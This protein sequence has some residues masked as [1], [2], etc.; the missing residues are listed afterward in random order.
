MT[1]LSAFLSDDLSTSLRGR[2]DAYAYGAWGLSLAVA[3]AQLAARGARG[4]EDEAARWLGWSAAA[5]GGYAILQSLGFDPIFKIKELPTGGRAV[6]TLGSPVD[7][8][9]FLALLWPVA[10]R[11]LDAERG[12][13]PAVLAAAVAGGLVASGSRGALLAACAGTAGYWLMSRREGRSALPAALGIAALASA[14]AVSWSF[15]SGAT[16]RDLSRIEVWK[17]ALAAFQRRP[18]LGWGPDGFEDAFKMLRSDRF[19]EL[20]GSST[21]QAY[22]HNDLLH[23]LS[24]MGLLGAA[25]Y[26]WLLV[27]LCLAAK[28]A[29]QAPEGRARAAALFSGL[30]ALWVNLAL[31]PVATEVVVLAAVCAGL[32]ASAT[33][34]PNSREAPRPLLV[35]LAGLASVSL[36]Y[37]AVLARADASYKRGAKAHVAGDFAAARKHIAFA[38]RTAPCELSYIT[39][40][41]NA[42]HD[43]INATRVVDARL[44]LLALADA[45]GAA[46]VAC[47]PRKSLAHYAAGSAARMRA[48]LGFSDRLPVAIGEFDR[49]LEL[50]PKFVPLLNARR[51]AARLLPPAR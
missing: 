39:G 50:D 26:A 13:L 11:R 16:V 3:A 18:W 15:R 20:L 7:L 51:D 27:V 4:R 34:P 1:F 9:A 6:S 41:L 24:G 31:N 32:L 46:A 30:L 28:Q 38:R 36:I 44:E 12:A 8:G 5:V 48:D 17:A 42:I 2:Y 10:L 22:A 19:V 25:A 45:A 33:A 29:L 37:A 23:V 14:F 40:E 49:A 35:L 43:W 47:H 21:Y